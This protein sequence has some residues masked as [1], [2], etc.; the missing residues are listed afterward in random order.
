MS[1]LIGNAS[2]R[3]TTRLIVLGLAILLLT[4]STPLLYPRLG[5][6][7]FIAQALIC[8]VLA[9]VA[10]RVAEH[11]PERNAL[12]IILGFAVVL[13]LVLVVAP[14][15]ISNDVLRYVWDG[16]IQAAGFNPYRYFPAAPELAHLRDAVIYPNLSKVDY[17][18]TIY[19]PVAEM[20]FLAVTQVHE[21]VT[22]MKLALVAFEAI[23]IA[24]LIALLRKI[25]RPASRVV[26]YAWHP[27]VLWEIAN[28][29]HV[30]GA[31]AALMTLALWLFAA[32]RPLS[33]GVA[34]AVGALFKPFSLIVL[35]AMWRP[36]DWRLPLVVFGVIAVLYLPYLSAGWGVFGHVPT[37]AREERLATDSAYWVLQMLAW[38]A[39]P[40]RWAVPL[41][42]AVS[43]AIIVGLALRAGFRKERP[44]A[45]TIADS[46]RLA[47][48]VCFLLSTD[49]P[50]YFLMAA[51]F[52]AL[53][54]SPAGWALTVG[55]V[56]LYDVYDWDPQV[57]FFVRDMAFNLAVLAGVLI[58]LRRMNFG[59]RGSATAPRIAS[60]PP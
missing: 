45:V 41:Y 23:T 42:L 29:G 27:L 20:L 59:R 54:G 56:L 14:P 25:G 52:V 40:T 17:A 55:G 37:Y 49:Y 51:P 1:D 2:F 21:S 43:L 18:V 44:L 38:I 28:N 60:D 32:G 30:D 50:W 26:A 24:A 46:N 4:G 11:C 7:F 31:M 48:A 47:L 57:H 53:T 16:R 6:N 58:S 3:P 35:P 5:D 19:P 12:L 39:G 9:F 33:A 10:T 13:R 34:A 15:L 22:A 8:G 36:W